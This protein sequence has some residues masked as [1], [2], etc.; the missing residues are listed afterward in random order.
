[1]FSVHR[2]TYTP[3]LQ[4]TT[5]HRHG[6]FVC[7]GCFIAY[8][9]P[10]ADWQRR[11]RELGPCVNFETCSKLKSRIRRIPPNSDPEIKAQQRDRILALIRM[12]L[13]TRRHVNIYLLDDFLERVGS[14]AAT[15]LTMEI[16]MEFPHD[17]QRITV[18]SPNMKPEIV[19]CC[20]TN[21]SH[22]RRCRFLIC[23]RY[24]VPRHIT[25]GD[26]ERVADSTDT[27]MIRQHS[28]GKAE[29]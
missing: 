6:A 14:G 11:F 22:K 5:P 24:D 21:I 13:K 9:P 15:L 19:V 10:Q 28:A 2:R 8:T 17:L 26:A 16:A 25:G 7:F 1:M 12:L 23:L 27:S 20:H 4:P 29:C 18:W 3:R